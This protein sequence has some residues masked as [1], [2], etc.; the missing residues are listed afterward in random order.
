M[1]VQD[2]L[3][4]HSDEKYTCVQTAQAEDLI[5]TRPWV[6]FGVAFGA[7]YLI[8]KLTRSSSKD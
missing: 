7:G 4:F 6:S 8:A 5:R 2:I 3:F 1:A